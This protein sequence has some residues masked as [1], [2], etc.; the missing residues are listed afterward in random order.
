[1]LNDASSVATR[2]YEEVVKF[3]ASIL[4][5]NPGVFAEDSTTKSNEAGTLGAT[6]P[7]KINQTGASVEL[8]MKPGLK[9]FIVLT[10]VKKSS[11]K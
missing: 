5:S 3:Q 7:S 1:M 6:V 11:S 9:L 10:V 2:S 4:R 8:R